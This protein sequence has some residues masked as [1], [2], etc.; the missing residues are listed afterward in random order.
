MKNKNKSPEQLAK[1]RT[2]RTKWLFARF[3]E[4]ELDFLLSEAGVKPCCSDRDDK[5]YQMLIVFYHGSLPHGL[6]K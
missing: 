4:E 2:L 5:L 6:G 3:S 1:E